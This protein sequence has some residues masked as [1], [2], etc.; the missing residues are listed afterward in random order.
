MLSTVM[1][2]VM[3]VKPVVPAVADVLVAECPLSDAANGSLV[4]PGVWFHPEGVVITEPHTFWTRLFD[5]A[6]WYGTARTSL[7][8]PRQHFC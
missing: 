3:L 4:T 1:A 7:Q 2:V 5:P 8:Q 6:D